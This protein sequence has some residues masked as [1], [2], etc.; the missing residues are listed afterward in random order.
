MLS[1]TLEQ[2]N[3]FCLSKQHLVPAYSNT[4]VYQVTRD[5]IGLQAVSALTPYLSLLARIRDFSPEGLLKELYLQKRLVKVKCMRC[6]LF[7]LPLD[8][9]EA[10]LVATKDQLLS[11]DMAKTYCALAKTV[12]KI[13][14]QS[15]PF[16]ASE[17]ELENCKRLIVQLLKNES[18]TIE[19]LKKRLDTHVNISYIVY[20]LCDDHQLIRGPTTQ[21]DNNKH[22]YTAWANRLPQVSFQMPKEQARATLIK[23]YIKSYG[24]VCLEDIIWWTGFGKD[25]T[26]KTLKELSSGIVEV[27]VDCFEGKFLLAKEDL[28][29]LKA[30]KYYDEPIVSFLPAQDN[31]MVAYRKRGRH[32]LR[33]IYHK[34]HDRAGNVLPVILIDGQVAGIWDR[35]DS[36][37]EYTL[38]DRVDVSTAHEV[39]EKAATVSDFLR[40]YL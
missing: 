15:N 30:T 19:Q 14:G 36:K 9:V 35:S 5:V 25:E 8:I 6:S 24:P 31:Y 28:L 12:E 23:Q 20:A 2:V 13:K 40:K 1:F 21:W 32:S 26:I 10:A 3:T 4:D 17:A 38:F 7:I 27:S 11:S 29:R 37:V 22:H 34:I 16:E 18:L 39:K 33:D